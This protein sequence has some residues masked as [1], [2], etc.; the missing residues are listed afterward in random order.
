[1]MSLPASPTPG[2]AS[3]SQVIPKLPAY[4]SGLDPGRGFNIRRSGFAPSTLNCGR[5]SN[6]NRTLQANDNPSDGLFTIQNEKLKILLIR[7]GLEPFKGHWALPG[8]FVR[9]D[10]N[11]DAAIQREL[12]ESIQGTASAI[13]RSGYWRRTWSSRPVQSAPARTDLPNFSD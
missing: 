5:N 7:R 2:K 9:I 11:L 8:G 4:Q 3:T 10:E 12:Y 6:E 1:M 13:S